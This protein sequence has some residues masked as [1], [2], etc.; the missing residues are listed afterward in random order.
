MVLGKNPPKKNPNPK[1]NSTLTLTLFFFLTSNIMD[2][3]TTVKKK[4][5]CFLKNY[6][7]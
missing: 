2:Q 3:K 7:A 5:T 4:V 6:V 1:P